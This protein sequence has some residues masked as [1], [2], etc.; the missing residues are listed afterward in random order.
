MAV[1][2]PVPCTK[3]SS[4]PSFNYA[5]IKS[6]PQLC[7]VRAVLSIQLQSAATAV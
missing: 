4:P 7:E 5:S 2:L 1:P 3:I 6:T